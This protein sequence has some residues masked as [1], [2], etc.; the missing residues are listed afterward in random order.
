MFPVPSVFDRRPAVGHLRGGTGLHRPGARAR[1]LLDHPAHGQRLRWAIEERKPT[2]EDQRNTFSGAVAGGEGAS[3]SC[4]VSGTALL[5][6]LYGLA[7]HRLHSAVLVRRQLRRGRRRNCAATCSPSSR[8]ARWRRRRWRP[9]RRRVGSPPESWAAPMIVWFLGSAARARHPAAAVFAVSSAEPDPDPIRR[10]RHGFSR[11]RAGRRL[12]P[13]VDP[14]LAHRD[15]GPGRARR[16][17]P[18][19]AGRSRLQSGRVRRHRTRRA[20]TRVQLD[21]RRVART[22]TGAR[23]LRPPRRA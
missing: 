21:G 13:D 17:Q 1:H 18:R 9:A 16:A 12:H 19:R 3:S 23:S 20:A 7:E 14:V 10:R 11:C 4:G 5:T 2:H 15:P 6:T 22:R 8:C